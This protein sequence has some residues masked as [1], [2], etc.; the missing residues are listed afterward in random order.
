MQVAK[1]ISGS[2]DPLV[3]IAG[4]MGELVGLQAATASEMSR[5][6]NELTRLGTEM[7]RKHEQNIQLMTQGER[8]HSELLMAHKADDDKHFA[9]LRKILYMIVYTFLGGSAVLGAVWGFI[10]WVAPYVVKQ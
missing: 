1:R 5:F 9:E 2:N 4:K 8:Q 7:D 3:D 6:N 10:Q